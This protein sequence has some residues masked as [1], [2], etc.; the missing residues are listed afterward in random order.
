MSNLYSIKCKHTDLYS[1]PIRSRMD[2]CPRDVDG[3]AVSVLLLLGECCK[4]SF[5]FIIVPPEME[6]VAK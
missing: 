4:K 1:L 5:V 6:K 3:L 2:S